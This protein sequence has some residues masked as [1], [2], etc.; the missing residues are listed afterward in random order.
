M[1]E[2]TVAPG[3]AK[4]VHNHCK[5]PESQLLKKTVF[6]MLWYHVSLCVS[7]YISADY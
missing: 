2:H 3:H 5:E 6:I 7:R 4:Y 1:Q